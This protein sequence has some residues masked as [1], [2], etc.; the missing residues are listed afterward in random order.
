MS[1][2]G[3]AKSHFLDENTTVGHAKSQFLDEILKLMLRPKV[4]FWIC[5]KSMFG[6]NTKIKFEAKS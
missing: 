2:F 3:Y 4:D 5:P 6:R 1:P